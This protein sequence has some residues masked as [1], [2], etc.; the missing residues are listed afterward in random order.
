MKRHEALL[1]KDP[2][3]SHERWCPGQN[4]EHPAMILEKT[5]PP[6][7]PEMKVEPMLP[8]VYTGQDA[9]RYLTKLAFIQQRGRKEKERG[10]VEKEKQE[11][12]TR[13]RRETSC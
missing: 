12:N 6:E 1:L 7:I 10:E 8:S 9:I 3:A 5:D 11:D 13:K 4:P 2:P